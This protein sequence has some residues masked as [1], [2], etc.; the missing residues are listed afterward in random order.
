MSNSRRGLEE[1]LDT[2]EKHA[3][4]NRYRFNVPKCC[5]LLEPQVAQHEPL[6][7]HNQELPISS[8]FVYLGC[9]FTINGIDWDEHFK[10][11]GAKA[12]GSAAKLSGA[13]LCARN[14]G[15]STALSLFGSFVRPILEYGMALAPTKGLKNAE[16]AYKR[17]ICWTSSTGQGACTD[18]IGLFA[19]ME[20]LPTRHERL[21]YGFWRK[22]SS[23][24]TDTKEFAVALARKAHNRK[25]VPGSIFSNISRLEMIQIHEQYRNRRAFV[26]AEETEPSWT[27]RKEEVLKETATK[28]KS[29]YIFGSLNDP[30]DRRSM[31]AA[32]TKLTPNEQQ[33]IMLWTLNRAVGQWKTCRGCNAAPGTKDH[34]ER[35]ILQ[36]TGT[37]VG[38]S[39][40]EDQLFECLSTPNELRRISRDIRRCIGDRPNG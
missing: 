39:R 19:N 23:L 31:K 35:C 13:G 36:L 21:A 2:C 12:M 9:T 5:L 6:L 29:A 28:Y 7:L 25:K 17:T 4:L 11:L 20:P 8:D 18:V 15:L 3:R 27:A 14:I 40:L 22:T 10:R 34:V 30:N 26:A 1:L 37:P 24:I 33:A 32:F 38:P 16:K